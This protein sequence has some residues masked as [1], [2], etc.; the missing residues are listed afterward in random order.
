MRSSTVLNTTLPN[1]SYKIICVINQTSYSSLY[2]LGSDKTTTSSEGEQNPKVET[3]QQISDKS[4]EESKK[5]GE[6]CSSTI[7]DSEDFDEKHVL[8]SMI[9]TAMGYLQ[10]SLS[11]IIKS[12]MSK[13]YGNKETLQRLHKMEL[14]LQSLSNNSEEKPGMSA[15]F[16]ELVK[17]SCKLWKS[18][19]YSKEADDSE[20]ES[21]VWHDWVWHC[22]RILPRDKK[23][24]WNVS[25]DLTSWKL[26]ICLKLITRAKLHWGSAKEE[27]LFASEHVCFKTSD[28]KQYNFVTLAEEATKVRNFYS[29]LPTYKD[30]IKQYKNHFNII[31]QFSPA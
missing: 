25:E 17:N 31:E 3:D 4:V 30:I 26:D 16:D 28:H 1:D 27:L 7:E 12:V 14:E 22:K 18:G 2:I 19:C 9:D 10:R 29:H 13:L 5:E 21:W 11:I 20:P 24:E 15:I 8:K 6:E 23:G